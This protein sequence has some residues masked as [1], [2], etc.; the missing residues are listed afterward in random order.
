MLNNEKIAILKC[1]FTVRTT[2]SGAASIH[3]GHTISILEQ[4]CGLEN[5]VFYFDYNNTNFFYYSR[6]VLELINKEYDFFETLLPTERLSLIERITCERYFEIE[7]SIEK[8]LGIDSKIGIKLLEILLLVYN[9]FID[10]MIEKD[11]TTFL[12]YVSPVITYQ[13]ILMDLIRKRVPNAKILVLDDYTFEP[14]TP[15]YSAI[16]TGED[17]KT[18]KI[19]NLH[20]QDPLAHFVKQ[21]IVDIIDIIIEGEGYDFLRL[22]F[23]NHQG[24]NTIKSRIYNRELELIEQGDVFKIEDDLR[25][26]CYILESGRVDLDSLPFPNFS[27]MQD[28]YEFAEIEFT[29]GCNYKCLF[30]ERSNM[31]E[32]VLSRHSVDYIVRE[33][34]HIKKY[35]FKYITI[36]DCCINIDEEYSIDVLEAIKEREIYFEYQCNLRG[37]EPN[38]KLLEL[39]QQT[40][41]IEVAFGIETTDEDVLKSMNKEQNLEIISSLTSAVHKYKMRLMIFLI[42]GFPTEKLDAAKRTLDFI[43]ELNNTTKIDIIE[44]EFYRAGHIQALSPRVYEHFGIEIDSNINREG[45]KKSS[46]L[47]T[48]LGFLGI[49]TYEKGMSRAELATAIDAYVDTC[50]TKGIPLATFYKKGESA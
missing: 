34:E 15:Y 16:I 40:G 43:V 48:E 50:K 6:V 22:Y 25:G 7:E 26:K 47:Y 29:R 46:Y 12:V 42:I 20:N 37:K 31:M 35:N 2:K 3:I 1:P 18:R 27:Q 24:I 49:A 36:I 28:I 5:Q 19:G 33:L 32:N 38:E 13:L 11:C 8:K 17:R 9:E 44:L 41:C 45:L 10:S 23:G 30:C 4:E 21:K 14:A 39:L